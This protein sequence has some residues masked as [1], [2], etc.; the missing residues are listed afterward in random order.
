MESPLGKTTTLDAGLFGR[1]V[2][3]LVEGAGTA[4]GVVLEV[5]MSVLTVLKVTTE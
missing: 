4:A 5:Q 2:S 3:L 1:E